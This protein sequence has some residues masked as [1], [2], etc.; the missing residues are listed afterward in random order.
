VGPRTGEINGLQVTVIDRNDRPIDGATVSW[1]RV[2]GTSGITLSQALTAD[3]AVSRTGPDGVASLGTF[4]C[5]TPALAVGSNL[6]FQ[7][8][9]ACDG[10]RQAQTFNFKVVATCP[11]T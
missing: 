3:G 11:D 5:K 6:D 4:V 2:L 8:R 9:A 7:V 1:Q 10:G